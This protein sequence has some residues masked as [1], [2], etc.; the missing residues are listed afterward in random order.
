[1][2]PR[3]ISPDLIRI[4]KVAL[5]VGVRGIKKVAS[6]MTRQDVKLVFTVKLNKI[7]RFTRRV[8]KISIG[9]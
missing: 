7:L 8:L 6:E 3:N 5:H 9:F 4:P 2:I 1:L